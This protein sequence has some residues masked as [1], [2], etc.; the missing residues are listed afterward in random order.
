MGKWE[1]DNPHSLYTQNSK[2]NET[3]KVLQLAYENEMDVWKYIENNL[4]APLKRS[5]SRGVYSKLECY[6]RHH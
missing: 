3:F 2:Y 6:K 4:K 1:H 5:K